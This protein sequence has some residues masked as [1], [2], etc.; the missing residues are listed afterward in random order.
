M[1]YLKFSKIFANSGMGMEL[2]VAGGVAI[3]CCAGG[4][5]PTTEPI[6]SLFALGLP[7][8][9]SFRLKGQNA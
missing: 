9:Q 3:K 1:S 2:H 8:H 5:D 7:N 4:L 6:K